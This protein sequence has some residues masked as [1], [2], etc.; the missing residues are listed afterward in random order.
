MNGDNVVEITKTADGR[1]FVKLPTKQ[2]AVDRRI[3]RN[4]VELPDAPDRTN[5]I[6]LVVCYDLYGLSTSRCASA[7]GFTEH[8]IE[9]IRETAIYDE[10]KQSI[11][12]NIGAT[13]DNEIKAIF[14]E[15]AKKAAKV[16]VEQL[17]SNTSSQAVSAAMKILGFAGMSHKPTGQEKPKS[18]LNIIIVD[19]NTK[20]SGDAT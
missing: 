15:N 5:P 16:L 19:G 11:I 17:D 9:K 18:G 3:V 14:I 4:S 8:Q 1:R 13:G 2:K 10:I 12:S 6:A 20:M 7:L